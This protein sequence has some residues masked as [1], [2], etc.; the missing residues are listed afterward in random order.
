MMIYNKYI[1]RIT[2]FIFFL[3]A[4]A[5][6]NFYYLRTVFLYN[7][8]L[9]LVILLLFLVGVFFCLRNILLIKNGHMYFMTQKKILLR[10]KI[11]YKKEKCFLI[12]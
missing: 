7:K 12:F 8:E 9:N 2:L 1:I 3:L 6:I 5:L 11:E 4:V 10:L